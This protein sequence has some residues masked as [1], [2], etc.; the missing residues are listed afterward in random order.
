MKQGLGLLI[1][2]LLALLAILVVFLGIQE[3]GLSG[4]QF[5]WGAF[6]A[7]SAIL[8]HISKD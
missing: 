1:E 8:M 3:G 6:F 5:F 2:L 7:L 4:W